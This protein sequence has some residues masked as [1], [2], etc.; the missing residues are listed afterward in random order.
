MPADIQTTQYLQTKH[1]LTRTETTLQCTHRTF[2]MGDIIAQMPN[3]QGRGLDSFEDI[4]DRCTKLSHR[5]KPVVAAAIFTRAKDPWYV[6]DA[7]GVSFV[8]VCY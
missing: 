6:M 3:P 4:I 7:T 2:V 5:V 1:S 8:G